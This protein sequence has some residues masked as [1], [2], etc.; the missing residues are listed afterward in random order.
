MDD[1]KI[2]PLEGG[3]DQFDFGNQCPGAEDF[4]DNTLIPKENPR[5]DTNQANEDIKLFQGYFQQI[6]KM[7][8][9]YDNNFYVG[10]RPL[11]SPLLVIKRPMLH[12]IGRFSNLS[13]RTP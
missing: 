11:C 10:H 12:W 7:S 8:K 4:P 6:E 2:Q 13:A 1:N 5:T 9:S 3:I